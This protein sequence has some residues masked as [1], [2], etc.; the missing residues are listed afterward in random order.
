[1]AKIICIV[2]LSTEKR[3]QKTLT[4]VTGSCDT[5]NVTCFAPNRV[6]TPELSIW[7]SPS[8]SID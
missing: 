8:P 1:M 5:L 6:P 7:S 4:D 2:T 3:S